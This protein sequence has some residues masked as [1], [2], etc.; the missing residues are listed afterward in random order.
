MSAPICSNW[1]AGFFLFVLPAVLMALVVPAMGQS[2]WYDPAG[3]ATD[4]F[5]YSMTELEDINNDGFSEF[6][7]G[8][9]GSDTTFEAGQ[10]FLWFGGGSVLRAPDRI[11]NGTSPEMFGSAVANIGDVNSDGTPDWAVGAPESNAGGSGSGRVCIYYGG[12]NPSATP[13]VVITGATGGHK[14]GYSISAAGDF[15]GDGH[16]DF[17]VGAPMANI[18]RGFTGAAY[19]IYG[20]S[21]GPS[22]NLATATAFSGE[23]A[24]DR[25]GWS[26]SDAGNYLGG[27][28]DCVAV[29]AP[30]ANTHGGIDAGAV[31]V[32]EGK[33]AGATPDTTIDFVAGIGT[34]SKS[35]SQFGFAVRGVGRIDT[36][37]YDDL[38]VGA[39]FSNDAASAAGRVEIFY[40]DPS[41]SVV[42]GHAINGQAATDNFGYSLDRAGDILGSG[43]DDVLIGAPFRDAGGTDAGKAYVYEGGSSATSAGGLEPLLSGSLNPPGENFGW[44]VANAGDFDGDGLPDFAVSAVRGRNP[45]SNASSGVVTLYHSSGGPVAALVQDWTTTWTNASEVDLA[46]TF[47]LP[48]DRFVDLQLTRQLRNEEGRILSEQLVWSGPARL[49]DDG[50]A[51]VLTRRAAGFGYRDDLSSIAGTDLNLSYALLAVTDTGENLRLDNMAGPGVQPAPIAVALDMDPVWPNPANPAVTVRFRAAAGELATVQVLDVRGHV[52]RELH[53]AA[54]LGDW[55]NII[56]NGLSDEGRAAASG[57][58]LIRLNSGGELRTQRVVLAR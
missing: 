44:A 37:S 40:G 10:V 47:S 53:Q 18:G 9:A 31:Y 48:A 7:I 43:A 49:Q 39:P 51:G 14:F 6:L 4:F 28:E 54:G 16:D 3:V 23:I 38:A 58:Y 5:G 15:D 17:I 35:G 2:Y 8:V 25:F 33:L 36:D 52:V 13:D 55:Q 26:V 21:G 56:W 45:W 20:G 1:R 27:N 11:W 42:A 34:A 29:G 22:T 57:V 41:P 32:F 30:L 19:V 12:S 50:S 46:F 24:E